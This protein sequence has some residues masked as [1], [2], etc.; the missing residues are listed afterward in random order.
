MCSPATLNLGYVFKQI[1]Q[2]DCCLVSVLKT[3]KEKRVNGMAANIVA[4]M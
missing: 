1:K 4:V 3:D 2:L